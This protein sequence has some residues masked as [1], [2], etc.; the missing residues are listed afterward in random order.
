MLSA[1]AQDVKLHGSVQSVKSGVSTRFRKTKKRAAETIV[2]VVSRTK[3]VGIFLP[4]FCAGKELKMDGDGFF[5]FCLILI[6]LAL[7]TYGL[8]SI[9]E[10]NTMRAERTLVCESLGYDDY[11]QSSCIQ[12]ESED[13]RVYVSYS[14]VLGRLN[15]NE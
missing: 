11:N 2:P 13:V 4:P 12:V 10:R 5:A 7:M 8:V 14:L 6:V 9:V 15:N 3:G 1:T